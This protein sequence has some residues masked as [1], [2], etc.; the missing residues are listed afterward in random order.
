[1]TKRSKEN[2]RERK[3]RKRALDQLARTSLNDEDEGEVWDWE[4]RTFDA[5]VKA[6]YPRIKDI[7]I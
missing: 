2:K 7:K 1:M 3:L 4:I 5:A 6:H